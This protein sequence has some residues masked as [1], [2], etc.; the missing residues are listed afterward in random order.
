MRWIAGI[1]LTVASASVAGPIAQD[2]ANWVFGHLDATVFGDHVELGALWFT[3]ADCESRFGTP[4]TV[5]DAD[6]RDQLASCLWPDRDGPEWYRLGTHAM[7]VESG[8]PIAVEITI[9]RGRI[10]ALGGR[11]ITLDRGPDPTFFPSARVRAAIDRS[12]AGEAETIYKLCHDAG[13]K[14]TSRHVLARSGSQAFDAEAERFAS[15]LAPTPFAPAGTPL[16]ACDIVSLRYPMIDLATGLA[17]HP[18]EDAETISTAALMERHVAGD[19]H[20]EPDD[21]T[22]VEIQRSGKDKIIGGFRLCID[23]RGD[24]DAIEITKSTGFAAFDAELET[25]M[26]TWRFEPFS[27]GKCAPITVVYRQV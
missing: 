22:K 15:R 5:D 16:A 6:D 1:V 7:F 26:R 24:V 14:L 21:V 9:R 4:G 11:A 20:I 13:G 18:D 12:P 8:E 17:N 19:R 25:Q 10:T 2:D 3:N 27:L 23:A